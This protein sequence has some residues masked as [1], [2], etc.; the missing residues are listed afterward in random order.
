MCHFARLAVEHKEEPQDHLVGQMDNA[1]RGGDQTF[2]DANPIMESVDFDDISTLPFY[3]S[4]FIG[5][6][7]SSLCHLPPKVQSTDT[8]LYRKATSLDH[9]RQKILNRGALSFRLRNPMA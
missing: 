2:P 6:W 9:F 8:G 1:E 7:L 3:V 4:C 5:M